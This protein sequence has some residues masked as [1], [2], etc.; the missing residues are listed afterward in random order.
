MAK[1]KTSVDKGIEEIKKLIKQDKV[2]IGSE[3]VLKGLRSNTLSRI[4]VASNCKEETVGTINQYAKL[5]STQVDVL[6]YP[7]DELGVLCKKPFAISV[8]GVV[9]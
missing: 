8:L 7:N 6:K 1:K 4:M 3:R 5:S 9:K 2:V